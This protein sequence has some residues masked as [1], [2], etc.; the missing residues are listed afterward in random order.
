MA[1]AHEWGSRLPIGLL[2]EN[3]TLS[4]FEQHIAA[5]IPSCRSA[6][7][8]RRVI[9]DANGHPTTDLQT[10]FAELTIT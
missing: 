5:R 3:R 8:A 10:V 1:K 7:P 2:L 9:A 4:T 6:P